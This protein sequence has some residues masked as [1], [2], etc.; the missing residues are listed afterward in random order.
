MKKFFIICVCLCVLIIP[1]SCRKTNQSSYVKVFNGK[2]QETVLSS[3]DQNQVLE[4]LSIINNYEK[5]EGKMKT[6]TPDYTI[7]FGPINRNNDSIKYN[8]WMRQKK[9]I[10]ISNGKDDLSVS[11]YSS[12]KFYHILNSKNNTQ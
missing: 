6:D 8:L 3:K 5:Y 2:T 11:K 7:E 1:E 12:E 10:F 9:I 4:L